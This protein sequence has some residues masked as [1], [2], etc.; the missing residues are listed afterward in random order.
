M[1]KKSAPLPSRPLRPTYADNRVTDQGLWPEMWP[2]ARRDAVGRGRQLASLLAHPRSRSSIR[3]PILNGSATGWPAFSQ[4][5]VTL[6]DTSAPA[7]RFNATAI[8]IGPS[9]F[10]RTHRLARRVARQRWSWL[11]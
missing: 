6:V 9:R 5:L 11:P 10:L 8:A 2:L 1:S 4:R 3:P 7:D